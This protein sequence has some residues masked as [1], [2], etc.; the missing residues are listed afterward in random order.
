LSDNESEERF[1]KSIEERVWDKEIIWVDILIS[2]Y[3]IVIIIIVISIIK[4]WVEI[5]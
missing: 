5:N 4:R 3:L 2:E 1:N